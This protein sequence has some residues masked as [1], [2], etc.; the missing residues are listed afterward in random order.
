MRW[1]P[2]IRTLPPYHDD[3]VYIDALAVSLEAGLARLDFEPEVVIASF[4]GLPR[5]Y[6][7]KGDP[8][9]CQCQKTTRLL[10][11]RLGWPK[12]RLRITFQSRFGRAEW[13][14]PYTD[15]TIAELAR[16]GVRN[17]RRHHARASPPTASRRWRKSPSAPARRFA[18]PAGRIS[19]PSPASTT[20]RRAWRSSPTSSG[21]NCRGG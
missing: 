10:R 11:E 4:H 8:Y 13:L 5:D 1:Q 6:L 2:A 20:A 15:V 7:D 18:R 16:E 12:D 14:Q 3:P 9:H 19:P 21:A 17:A